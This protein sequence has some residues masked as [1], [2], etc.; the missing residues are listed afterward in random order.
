MF[1][2]GG[3][4]TNLNDFEKSSGRVCGA[5]CLADGSRVHMWGASMSVC[6]FVCFNKMLGVISMLNKVIK[7]S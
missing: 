4:L 1:Y 2:I 6:L 7:C 5:S 3:N